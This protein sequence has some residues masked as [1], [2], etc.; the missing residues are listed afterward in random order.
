MS[1]A[2]DVGGGA[3]PVGGRTTTIVL[4]FA[5]NVLFG[6]GL[7]FHAFLYNFY[8]EGVGHA[9]N[10]M[11][12]AAAAISAGGLLALI[13]AGQLIDRMGAGAAYVSAACVAAIGLATGAIVTAPTAIYLAAAVAGA[14][15]G[16]W[17]VTMAP[18]LIRLAPAT[19]RSRAFSWNTAFL[20]GSGALWTAG[21]GAAAAI[22]ENVLVTDRAG[23]LRAALLVGALATLSAVLIAAPALR[24]IAPGRGTSP[25]ARPADRNDDDAVGRTSRPP[26]VATVAVEVDAS[27]GATARRG[28]RPAARPR[29]KR[30][31]ASMV[32]P[33]GVALLILGIGVVWTAG[34]LALPFYNVYFERAHGLGI[35]RIGVLLGIGQALTAVAVFA[36]GEGAARFGPRRMLVGWLLLFPA[37]LWGLALAPGVRSAASFY[38]LQAFVLPSIYPLVDQIVLERVP[39][40]R[41][42]TASGWRN[43]ATEGSGLIGAAA[44]GYMLAAGNF[45]ALFMGAGALALVAGIASIRLLLRQSSD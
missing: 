18:A 28:A 12:V 16:A 35:E 25:D 26:P 2:P 30:R 22:F 29:A 7:Y 3:G 5:A 4:F 43:I 32:V 27:L 40:E 17:R 23:G 42:G 21:A 11:G 37:A 14:G 13:P 34:A 31:S 15:A 8:I 9:E 41:Q 38:L 1:A 44:G 39:R 19:F 20:V 45:E 24:R 6:S 10:V 36:S 33:R